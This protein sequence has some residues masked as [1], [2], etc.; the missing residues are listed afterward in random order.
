MTY[1]SHE[2][3]PQQCFRPQKMV[4]T[5]CQNSEMKKLWIDA[6]LNYKSTKFQYKNPTK[7]QNKQLFIFLT[8]FSRTSSVAHS[9]PFPL[10]FESTHLDQDHDLLCIDKE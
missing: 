6:C 5:K 9:V 8:P 4:Q 7:H 10:Y 1:F 3:R 2:N